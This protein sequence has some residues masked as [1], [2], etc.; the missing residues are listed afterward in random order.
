MKLSEADA[1]TLALMPLETI[2][3]LRAGFAARAMEGPVFE[4]HLARLRESHSG[5]ASDERIAALIRGGVPVVREVK[6]LR[7]AKRRASSSLE[8]DRQRRTLREAGIPT[9]E[10]AAEPDLEGVELL[11]R[12]VEQVRDR[13]QDELATSPVPLTVPVE[14][15][16]ALP[17]LDDVEAARHLALD[18]AAPA[19]IAK[20]EMIGDAAT[21]DELRT[22]AEA[23]RQRHGR[24][25]PLR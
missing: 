17:S 8:E 5:W 24:G 20:A 19:A 25:G 13:V 6:S 22:L 10:P 4:S 15:G 9:A 23:H 12:V 3:R 7:A 2:D 18:L 14:E 21:A 11:E 1:A 16:E